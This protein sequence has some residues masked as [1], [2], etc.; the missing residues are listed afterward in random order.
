M[1]QP[2]L[3]TFKDAID[4]CVD[5][6]SGHSLAAAQRDI[7]QAITMAMRDLE[8][9]HEWT[10]YVTPGRVHLFAP[11]RTGT[12][13]Y[14]HDDRSVN[15]ADGTFPT[16]AQDAYIRIGDVVCSV[17]SWING[18]ELILDYDLNPGADVAAGTSYTLYPAWYSLPE[19]FVSLAGPWREDAWGELRYVSPTEWMTLDRYNNMPGTPRY[20]TIMGVPDLHGTFGLFIYPASDKAKSLDFVY[21]RKPRQL[22]YSGHA[23]SDGV[24]TVTC[25]KDEKS[26]TGSST[27]FT[28][29]MIG[30]VIRFGSDSSNI[31]T[32]RDGLSPFIDER[33]VADWAS[34][35]SITLDNG[36]AETVSGVKYVVSDPVDID[37]VAVTAFFRCCEK[38]L[39]FSRN[40]K[41]KGEFAAGYEDALRYAKGNQLR[42]EQRTV[43]R[44]PMPWKR[45]IYYGT[46]GVDVP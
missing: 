22:R 34:A 3:L 44:A 10:Y 18:T 15:L 46:Q 11:Y 19:D 8:A 41:N 27:V 40:M 6:L 14:T 37:P 26:V 35:T 21:R 33:V 30:S 23:A 2:L 17:E 31:P 42:T 28:A 25:A 16:W 38:Q 43:C 29:A 36:L 39:A 9:A 24:G 4:H 45:R 7:R 1:S 32:A 20:Y 13:Q 5:F 12:V